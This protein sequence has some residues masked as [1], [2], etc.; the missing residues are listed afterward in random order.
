MGR[1]S[2]MSFENLMRT[3]KACKIDTYLF[4]NRQLGSSWDVADASFVV[5]YTNFKLNQRKAEQNRMNSR[6][7]GEFV[8]R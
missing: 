4:V 6:P 2:M 8:S 3:Q 5:G 7:I 1:A